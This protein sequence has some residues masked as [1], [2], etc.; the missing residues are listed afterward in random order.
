[1]SLQKQ[2][3]ELVFNSF[4]LPLT[5]FIAK[6]LGAEAEAV[7]EIFSATS[8]SAWKGWNTF[9]NKS[10]YFTWLC[11]IALNKI[12]DYYR[13]QIN[14]QSI[15]LSPALKNLAQIGSTEPNPEEKLALDEV[16][17]SVRACINLL[18]YDSRKLLY[19]RYWHNLSLNDIAQILGITPRSAEGR[20]YRA[21]AN[22]RK[23]I[24]AFL[25][26]K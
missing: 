25:P 16:C 23:K 26:S 14:T 8:I 17:G 11:R 22:L 6:R 15:F 5:K 7:D 19:M 3:F 4:T 13:E 2:S 21:K 18:P 9:Q 10:T 24:I 12:A 1:M 20:L